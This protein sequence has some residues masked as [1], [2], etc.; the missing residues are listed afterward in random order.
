MKNQIPI[1]KEIKRIACLNAQINRLVN[2]LEERFEDYGID[3]NSAE[4]VSGLTVGERGLYHG[5]ICIA[6][7]CDDYFVNQHTGYCE[8]SYYGQLYFR[9]DVPG[10]YVRVCCA[11]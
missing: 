2:I 7:W 9:T 4:L 11:C 6:E 1:Y 3:W 8:D 5:E 10:Q